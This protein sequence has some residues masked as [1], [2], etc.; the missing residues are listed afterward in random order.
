MV[1]MDRR[2]LI[3]RNPVGKMKAALENKIL[4]IMAADGFITLWNKMLTKVILIS[5]FLRKVLEMSIRFHLE[6]L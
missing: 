4:T 2:Q 5:H 6:Q 1:S 3:I